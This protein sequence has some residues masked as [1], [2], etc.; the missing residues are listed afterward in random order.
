MY[1][2]ATTHV[3]STILATKHDEPHHVYKGTTTSLLHWRST[4]R[5]ERTLSTSPKLI[6][7][8]LITSRKLHHYFQAYHVKVVSSFL[9]GNILHNRDANSRVFKWL[10]ELSTLNTDIIP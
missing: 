1:I 5:L 9:L 3:V 7:A 6:Y 8:L 10:I 2:T 4:Q